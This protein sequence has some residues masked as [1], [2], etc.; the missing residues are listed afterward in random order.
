MSD[1]PS[2]GNFQDLIGK[3]LVDAD[4]RKLI[5]SDRDQALQGY[6]LTAEEAKALDGIT[7]EMME[8]QATRVAGGMSPIVMMP[9]PDPGPD[10]GP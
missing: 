8:E 10:P 7:P 6:S 4:F 2:Q 9:S 1:T 3:A 5:Y